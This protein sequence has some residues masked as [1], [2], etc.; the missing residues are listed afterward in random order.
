MRRGTKN[1]LEV[2]ILTALHLKRSCAFGMEAEESSL[3]RTLFLH[4]TLLPSQ[5]LLNCP[6]EKLHSD[7]SVH[8]H[9]TLPH[10]Q[11]RTPI[12]PENKVGNGPLIQQSSR[13]KRA[14]ININGVLKIALKSG[15]MPIGSRS[16]GGYF[17]SRMMC[18][19]DF[20]TEF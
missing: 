5:F 16:D 18:H 19:F 20:D 13:G 10:Y 15:F 17:R 12:F 6:P 3:K 4:L 2:I 11:L 7:Y 8:H 9:K 14:H 1:F